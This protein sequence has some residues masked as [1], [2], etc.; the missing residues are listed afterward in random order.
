MSASIEEIKKW[1]EDKSKEDDTKT[2]RVTRLGTTSGGKGYR[3]FFLPP[4]EDSKEP[5]KKKAP[6]PSKKKD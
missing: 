6:A 2:L 1:L 5:A 4:V 3:V